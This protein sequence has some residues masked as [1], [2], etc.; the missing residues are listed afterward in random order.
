MT[1]ARARLLLGIT[2]VGSLVS[3]SAL[4]LWKELPQSLLPSSATF[5]FRELLQIAAV[6]GLF[7]L[8]LLPFDYYGGFWLPARFGKSDQTFGKWFRS[9]AVATATQALLFVIF[10]CLIVL[11]SQRLGMIGGVSVVIAGMI[12]CFVVRNRMLLYREERHSASDQNLL[13]ALGIIRSWHLAIPSILI[14]D[15]QDIGFT[16]GIVGWGSHARIVI[17]K[18]WLTFSSHQLATAIARRAVAVHNGSYSRGLLLAFAW[19]L[20]G[21]LIC[22]L[23]PGAGLASV[24]GLVTAICGFTIWSFLGLLTLPTVSRNAS[25]RIDQEL[26]KQ[27]VPSS[28]ISATAFS[29]DQLQDGEPA[30]SRLVETIFHPVPSLIS[31]NPREPVRGLSAWNVARTTLFLSWACLGLLSR[32]VHCNVGRP[33][34]WTMLPID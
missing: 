12:T 14:V 19:N 3:I 7:V 27:G 18:A 33:E 30:R 11:L 8:W 24:R 2:C 5:G 9:Y 25:L 23:I 29:M 16:G 13:N 34:L 21:F 26:A 4:A 31:R 20:T 10:S 17:P 1:Y 22:S 28:L 32:C 6:M 15:H